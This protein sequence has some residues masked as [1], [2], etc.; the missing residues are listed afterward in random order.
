MSS[1]DFGAKRPKNMVPVLE[2][3][4]AFESSR[5]EVPKL[6]DQEEDHVLARKYAALDRIFRLVVK[7]CSFGELV[8]EILRTSM[9][10]VRSESGSFLEVDHQNNC[11]FFRAVSGRS[12]Q[13]LLSVTVPA[14]HGVVGFVC[15]NKQPMALSSIDESSIY[16]RA[17]S[18]SVGFETR[19][20]VAY[21]VIIRGVTFGC[22][23][24]LNRLG[25]ERF[26]D[27]DKEILGAICE[28]AA[29]VIENRLV[30]AALYKELER[31][32]GHTPKDSS[33][34]DAA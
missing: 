8:S 1:S 13:N 20:V 2:E 6:F 31:L 28:Y 18:D 19:N 33:G 32:K 21:P 23:E 26:T 34:E 3:P 27:E 5:Q 30:N 9:E 25:E 24:L 4:P 12:S 14:G 17:I 16:L 22:L 7:D 10:L 11:L 15:E 29:K